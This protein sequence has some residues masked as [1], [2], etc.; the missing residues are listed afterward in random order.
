MQVLDDAAIIILGAATGGAQ[1]KHPLQNDYLIV[2][3]EVQYQLF[4]VE[5]SLFFLQGA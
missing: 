1:P 2:V 4:E 3:D 5:L